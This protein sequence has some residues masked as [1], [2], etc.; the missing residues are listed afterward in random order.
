MDA[1]PPGDQNLTSGAT[2][3]ATGDPP[4]Q[5]A[6]S[7]GPCVGNTQVPYN[8][9]L[10]SPCG[11]PAVEGFTIE[12]S[13]GEL[14]LP[15]P[16]I[17]E[18]PRLVTFCATSRAFGTS[19]EC[20]G[21]IHVVV[22]ACAEP[23]RSPCIAITYHEDPTAESPSWGG[24]F[25]DAEGQHWQLSSVSTDGPILWNNNP[26][27]GTFVATATLGGETLNLSGRFEVCLPEITT[28]TI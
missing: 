13:C 22:G 16:F 24:I 23:G 28:C 27:V 18:D 9:P 11:C 3:S 25:I 1:A 15:S 8:P 2:S 4:T 5:D 10:N 17:I 21:N 20:K 7:T 19:D 26:A 14:T 6:G 12:G